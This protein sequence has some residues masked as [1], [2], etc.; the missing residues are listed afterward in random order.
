MGALAAAGGVGGPVVGGAAGGGDVD[1]RG[2]GRR[3]EDDRGGSPDD[4][5]PAP[6]APDGHGAAQ[7]VE[8]VGGG[9]EL[10]H[11]AAQ[12]AAQRLFVEAA[13]GTRPAAGPHTLVVAEPVAEPVP[14]PLLEGA[15]EGVTEAA[16][17][18]PAV[19]PVAG[20]SLRKVVAHTGAS[21]ATRSAAMPREPYA[22]TEPSESP[23]VSATW[24]SV[25]S[26]K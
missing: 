18:I 17:R 9:F 13:L 11:G 26:A 19:A 2:Q 23:R 21:I 24:A 22:L 25:M 1:E 6:G 5:L 4:G 12:Q 20:V 15:P 16:V 3:T 8:R 10:A 7:L 14:D